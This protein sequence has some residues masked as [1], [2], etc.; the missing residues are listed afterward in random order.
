MSSFTMGKIGL[1][2][3]LAT[4]WGTTSYTNER[5]AILHQLPISSWLIEPFIS[6]AQWICPTYFS[7]IDQL[8]SDQGGIL[9]SPKPVFPRIIVAELSCFRQ[10]D[11]SS[12]NL[13]K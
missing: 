2:K 12:T 1:V 5:Q 8:Y 4:Q 13:G 6:Q 3:V 10:L 11:I 9:N 7:Q